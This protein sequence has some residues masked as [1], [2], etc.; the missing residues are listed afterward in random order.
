[1][2]CRF[3]YGQISIGKVIKRLENLSILENGELTF[4]NEQILPSL[5]GQGK[6]IFIDDNPINL[7]DARQQA[8]AHG[9][10][11]RTLCIG[12]GVENGI[13]YCQTLE[14]ATRLIAT[15]NAIGHIVCDMDD[16]LLHEGF[17]KYHQPRNVL[18]HF[19]KK[20]YIQ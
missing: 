9:L 13:E 12:E 18:T 16:V 17:R 15:E 11:I 5:K 10:P 7:I 2:A 19:I 4:F 8:R 3:P 6:V 1:L 20:G 14:Q